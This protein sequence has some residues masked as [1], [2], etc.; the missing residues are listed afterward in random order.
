MGETWCERRNAVGVVPVSQSASD[1]AGRGKVTVGR[2]GTRSPAAWSECE[3]ARKAVSSHRT[4]KRRGEPRCPLLDGEEVGAVAPRAPTGDFLLLLLLG[5][6][7]A[8]ARVGARARG[9]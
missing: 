4:P 6:C 3:G 8:R 9:G 2:S 1:E 7:R 5:L